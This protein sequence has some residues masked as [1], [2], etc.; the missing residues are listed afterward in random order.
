MPYQAFKFFSRNSRGRDFVVGDIH[1]HFAALENLLQRVQFN[2]SVDRVFSVGDMIDRGPE[3]HRVMEFLNYP[4]FHAVMGNH[5]RM[6]LDSAHDMTVKQNWI[7]YNGG[8]WW[9]NIPSLIKPR[10]RRTIGNLPI[11]FEIDTELGRVGIVHAD[12]PQSFNW[13]QFIN[14]LSLD[15]AVVEYALWSRQRFKQLQ[16]MGRTLPISQ[17]DLVIFGHTPVSR[18]VQQANVYYIDTGACYPQDPDLGHL[19]LLE[20][21]RGIKAYSIGIKVQDRTAP[22]RQMALS[23]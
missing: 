3:S 5:E 15:E 17:I 16:L 10:F 6:L 13:R 8:A 19:T 11:A 20:L 9:H 12:I 4:W 23:H 2:P 21:G 14:N 22:S 18:V 7:E 1:G